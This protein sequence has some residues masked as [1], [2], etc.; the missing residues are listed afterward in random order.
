M[1][2][3]AD[4]SLKPLLS[5][6]DKAIDDIFGRPKDLFL[7]TTPRDFLFD[8]VFLE[9]GKKDV[10]ITLTCKIIEKTAPPT[11]QL[12]PDGRFKFSLLGHVSIQYSAIKIHYTQSNILAIIKIDN[13]SKL[14]YGT[15]ILI[16]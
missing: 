6:L 8:G 3:I 5:M 16:T 14:L 7:R 11:L 12:M 2:N 13:F 15:I 9:C 1:I 4:E 10:L